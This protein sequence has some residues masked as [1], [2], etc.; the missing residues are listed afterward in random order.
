MELTY[1]ITA[2]DFI[3]F[4]LNFLR[5]NP[6]A[7]RNITKGRIQGAVLILFAG[8][9]FG[10]LSNRTSPLWYLLFAACAIAYFFLIPKYFTS[11][12]PGNV[13]KMLKNSS[14]TICGRK[15]LFLEDSHLRLVGEKE[16]N[17]YP[18]ER[19]QKIIKD[20]AQYYIYVGEMEALIIPFSAF[21]NE[22]AKMFFYSLL[23][24]KSNC[25]S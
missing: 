25:S 12:I 19:V 10:T 2:E 22:E 21:E 13:R 18:Y 7:K 14:N 11:R 8:I 4:N 6:R 20:A 16:D 5:V 1:E 23:Y 3:A 15:T 17:A 24:E 9:L